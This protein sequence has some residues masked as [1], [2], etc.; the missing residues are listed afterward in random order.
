MS[1]T[2]TLLILLYAISFPSFVSG[3]E[4]YDD[5]IFKNM[6]G[7]GSDAGAQEI[8]DLCKEEHI[9][10]RSSICFET[11]AQIINDIIF[12]QNITEPF[13]GNNICKYSN[14][15]V[16]SKGVIKDGKLD[17]RKTIWYDNGQIKSV[18]FYKDRKEDG[19][20]IKWY[21]NG[22]IKSEEFYKDGKEDGKWTNWF[23]NGQVWSE[24]Y[25]KDGK[26]DT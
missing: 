7:V 9:N 10:T 16:K 17:G 22:Q 6:K 1:K 5:C 23:E 11:E 3:S 18:E 12:L 20:W 25:Y 24:E 26:K 14:N 8:I 2:F 21:E 13:T 4:N 19:K 15:Q